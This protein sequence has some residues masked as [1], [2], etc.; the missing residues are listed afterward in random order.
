MAG[1]EQLLAP[2][3]HRTDDELPA[4]TGTVRFLRYVMPQGDDAVAPVEP[5]EPP[6]VLPGHDG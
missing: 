6:D 3:V 1:I 5:V 4:G 2:F